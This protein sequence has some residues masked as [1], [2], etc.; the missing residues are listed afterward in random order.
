MIRKLANTTM[1]AMSKKDLI[2]YIRDLEHNV[3][4]LEAQVEQQYQNVKDWQPVKK[5]HWVLRT[6]RWFGES[7][8]CS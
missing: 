1:M 8:Y 7:S 4:E 3:E 6:C 2:A 5:G